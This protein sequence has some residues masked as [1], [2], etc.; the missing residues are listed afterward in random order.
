[1]VTGSSNYGIQFTRST[2]ISGTYADYGYYIDVGFP[3]LSMDEVEATNHRSGGKQEFLMSRL[4]KASEFE[5][6]LNMEAGIVEL[7]YDDMASAT[8][9]WYKITYPSGV[10]KAPWNFEAFTKGV[11]PA[12]NA[13][14]Q[15]PA[16][17]KV[18]VTFLPTGGISSGL[19]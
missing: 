5:V 4:L 8:S 14:A 3:E 15:S 12:E 9:N 16:L 19:T 1:M 18:V 6:T 10:S 2:S 13:D 11:K 7:A 17:M